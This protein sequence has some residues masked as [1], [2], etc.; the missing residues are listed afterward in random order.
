VE[1]GGLYG[2]M[3]EVPFYVCFKVS[4]F[5]GPVDGFLDLVIL[6]F[7]DFERGFFT[8]LAGLLGLRIGD[9]ERIVLDCEVVVEAPDLVRGR[10][11]DSSFRGSLKLRKLASVSALG[12][13]GSFETTC[14]LAGTTGAEDN[15][16][17]PPAGVGEESTAWTFCLDTLPEAAVPFV[18]FCGTGTYVLLGALEGGVSGTSMLEPI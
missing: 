13:D 4:G 9:G 12:M 6:L 5:R 18:L 7:E 3:R 17:K 8:V 1:A 16:G 2:A 10:G 14:D 15:N 11:L